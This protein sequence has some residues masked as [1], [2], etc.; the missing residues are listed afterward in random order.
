MLKVVM[1]IL[2]VIMGYMIF[3]QPGIPGQFGI[4][5][6]GVI[7]IVSWLFG[8]LNVLVSSREIAVAFGPGWIKRRIAVSSIVSV[9]IVQ[10]SWL[11]G[12]GIRVIPNGLMFNI[13][14]FDAVEL[15]LRNGGVFRIGTDEPAR[16]ESAIREAMQMKG[17]Y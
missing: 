2:V 10:N 11:L 14:G 8:S 3:T 16:L 5:T 4:L 15:E 17:V 1:L 6:L 12:W 9:K 13:A 7:L